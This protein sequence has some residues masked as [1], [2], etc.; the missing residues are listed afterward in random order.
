METLMIYYYFV[1]NDRTNSI[2]VSFKRK[3]S[4]VRSYC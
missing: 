1:K 4:T 3:V 2:F